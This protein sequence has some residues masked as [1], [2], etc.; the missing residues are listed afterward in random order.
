[1]RKPDR[2]RTLALAAKDWLLEAAT[3]LA[4]TPASASRCQYYLGQIAE[5]YEGNLTL[6]AQYFQ[7]AVTSDANNVQAAR[8]LARIQTLIQPAQ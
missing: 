7:Q 1:L 8:A 4:G 6:A 3:G 5:S 2:A